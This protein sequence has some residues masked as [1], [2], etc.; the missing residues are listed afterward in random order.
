MDEATGTGET[1]E[2]EPAGA[3]AEESPPHAATPTASQA[4]TTNPTIRVMTVPTS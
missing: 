3:P 4:A 2:P 1:G